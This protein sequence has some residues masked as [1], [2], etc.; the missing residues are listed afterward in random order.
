MRNPITLKHDLYNR[1][2]FCDYK[3]EQIILEDSVYPYLEEHKLNTTST[4]RT[5]I[6]EVDDEELRELLS[7][8]ATIHISGGARMSLTSNDSQIPFWADFTIQ[9]SINCMQVGICFWC[10]HGQTKTVKNIFEDLL[11]DLSSKV[12]KATIIDVNWFYHEDKKLE[13]HSLKEII[14]ETVHGEAYP[15]I[16]VN[17]FIE[18]YFKSSSSIMIM[19]GAPGTGKT[20]LIRHIMRKATDSGADF[21]KLFRLKHRY[22]SEGDDGS[23]KVFA[24]KDDSELRVRIA[25]TTDVGVLNDENFYVR[26]RTGGFHFV[27]L[28]DIDFKLNSRKDGNELMH[29]FLALSDGFVSSNVKVIMSTNL[30]IDEID[31]ALTRPGR[32]YAAIE[33]RRLSFEEA[34]KLLTKLGTGVSPLKYGEYSIADV[35]AHA[36]NLS[37]KGAKESEKRVGFQIGKKK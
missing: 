33:T 9:D 7:K 22:D 11:R 14:Y 24:R 5:L 30:D 35:Y 8:I 15:Y 6:N 19:S 29:K 17:G 4:Y 12:S 25:Y 10:R 37:Y 34:S 2:E 36:Y 1:S 23:G 13:D 31:D 3:V 26:I 18:G 20:K 16:D 28:E 32:C 27:V 21:L